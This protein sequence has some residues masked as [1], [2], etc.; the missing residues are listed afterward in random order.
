MFAS[1]RRWEAISFLSAE[2]SARSAPESLTSSSDD[3]TVSSELDTQSLL[4]AAGLL[5]AP[6]RAASR[7]VIPDAFGSSLGHC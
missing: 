3:A 6:A 4:N 5:I 2:T 7:P 1:P